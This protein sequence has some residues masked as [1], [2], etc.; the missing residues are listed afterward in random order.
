MEARAGFEPA[1]SGFADRRLK[2]LGYRALISIQ[3]SVV[4]DQFNN[5]SFLLFSISFLL[6]TGN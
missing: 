6:I 5:F 1:N 2:P 3:F 4:S